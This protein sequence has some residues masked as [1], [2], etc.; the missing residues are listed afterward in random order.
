MHVWMNENGFHKE[1]KEEEEEETK[2]KSKEILIA[3]GERGRERKKLL[4]FK[5]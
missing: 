1:Q 4:Q 3:R 5:N 2:N